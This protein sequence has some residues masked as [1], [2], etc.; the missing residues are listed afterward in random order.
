[1]PTAPT[2]A[3]PSYSPSKKNYLK[4]LG[5]TPTR[6]PAPTTVPPP[7]PLISFRSTSSPSTLV[8]FS[9]VSGVRPGCTTMGLVWIVDCGL[10]LGGFSVVVN[11]FVCVMSGEGLWLLCMLVWKGCA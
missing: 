11:R 10:W 6:R 4:V 7:L 8:P 2:L 3:E 5:Y 1:M 9:L